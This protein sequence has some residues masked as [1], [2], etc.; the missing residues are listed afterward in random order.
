MNNPYA[1]R[2]NAHY[3]GHAWIKGNWLDSGGWICAD[4]KEVTIKMLM[5]P[6]NR[7]AERLDIAA[8][9]KPDYQHDGNY[10][11]NE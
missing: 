3:N 4:E 11:N 7:H 6:I 8:F 2:I 1:H 10:C 9:S 5:E